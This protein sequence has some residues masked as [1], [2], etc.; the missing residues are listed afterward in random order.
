[1]AASGISVDKTCLTHKSWCVHQP[2]SVSV[3]SRVF[4][5]LWALGDT[6]PVRT[7]S[8]LGKRKRIPRRQGIFSNA[9][10][11]H[12]CGGVEVT[13]EPLH[14]HPFFGTLLERWS[15]AH[16]ALFV[17]W[18]SN[19][20]DYFD[21]RSED[22]HANSE[23]AIVCL[24][25][26]AS[27]TLRV[28][29]KAGGSIVSDVTLNDGDLFVMGGSFQSEFLHE[30]TRKPVSVGSDCRTIGITLRAIKTEE[31]AEDADWERFFDFAAFRGSESDACARVPCSM[32]NSEQ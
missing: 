28:R 8:V 11:S 23:T 31:N 22:E 15:F 5:E 21:A 18:Y 20:K 16:N 4:D 27:R 32:P 30:I 25:L 29:Q 6:F 12:L 7:L 19:G 14:A 9:L 13:C 26:G 2:E 1:M 17:N 24:T 3:S 10:E